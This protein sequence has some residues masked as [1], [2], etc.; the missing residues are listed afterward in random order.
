MLLLLLVEVVADECDLR[1]DL[2][3]TLEEND[4]PHWSQSNGQL[5]LNEHSS[6]GWSM[7]S[8]EK[9]EFFYTSAI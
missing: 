3:W 6:P 9:K 2:N 1:C 5:L 7:Y 4:L 8:L